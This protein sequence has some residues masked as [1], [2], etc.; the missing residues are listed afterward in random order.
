[1]KCTTDLGA[2]NEHKRVGFSK[3]L[4]HSNLINE[5]SD[6]PEGYFGP[7]VRLYLLGD[8]EVFH[9]V[10]NAFAQLAYNTTADKLT[11]EQVKAIHRMAEKLPAADLMFEELEDEVTVYYATVRGESLNRYLLRKS[12]EQ[13]HM[14]CQ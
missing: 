10:A 14:P 7:D 13:F 2:N 11:K 1:M 4:Q 6:K 5:M 9:Q 12:A 3:R 8:G